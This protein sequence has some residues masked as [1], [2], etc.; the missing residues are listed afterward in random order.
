M[1]QAPLFL[2]ETK[3]GFSKCSVF[4]KVGSGF[5]T[6]TSPRASLYEKVVQKDIMLG[7]RVKT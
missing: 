1:M 7:E 3:M 5:E 4:W 2:C 6:P